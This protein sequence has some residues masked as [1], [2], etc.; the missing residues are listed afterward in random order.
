MLAAISGLLVAVAFPHPFIHP[1]INTLAWIGLIPLLFALQRSNLKTTPLLGLAFGLPFFLTVL[2]WI[3]IFGS[4]AWVALGIMLSLWMILFALGAWTTMRTYKGAAQFV[5]LPALWT[6]CELGRS[7]GPWGFSWANLGSTVD[8]RYLL[9]LASYV[10]EYGLSFVM[11]M[12]NLIGLRVI[13]FVVTQVEHRDREQVV[14]R[15]RLAALGVATLIASVAIWPAASAIVVE[16]AGPGGVGAS[17]TAHLAETPSSVKVAIIQANVPQILKANVGNDDAIKARYLTMTKEALKSKPDLI[18]WPESALVSYVKDEQGFLEE[19]NKLLIP[20][21]TSLI[22]G[23]FE[24]EHGFTHN[25]AF[26]FDRFG[27]RQTY[28]KIHL[29]PFGEYIPMRSLV[30]RINNL[31]TLVRNLSPGTEYKVFDFPGQVEKER[32]ACTDT[33]SHSL[34]K[35][36]TII[37]FESSD[38]PLVGRMVNAGARALVV[39]TNDGWFGKTAALEQ[40]FRITRMRAAEYG[41]PV[42][43]A[44]NTGISGIIDSHGL[45]QEKSGAERQQVISGTLEFSPGTSFF[46]RYGSLMPYLYLTIALVGVLYGF[47][48]R[49]T[50]PQIYHL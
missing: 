34:G 24:D 20:K 27:R 6:L 9:Q 19:V 42:I 10:G 44:A 35:F 50:I 1:S 11:V 49:T 43:Q 39:I 48:K 25:N 4:I 2:Y 16:A 22:F 32:A 33:A 21:K 7:L 41:I 12:V 29:V 45:I 13:E 37:C 14:A 15:M 8:N 38:S 36:S 3:R 31:A 5:I 23:I 17:R 30:E 28:R 46:A 18:I 47:A 26:F 40:H